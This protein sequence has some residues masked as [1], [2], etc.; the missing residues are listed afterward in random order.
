MIFSNR[1]M[2]PFHRMCIPMNHRPI[3]YPE[4]PKQLFSG[5]GRLPLLDVLTS[6][7]PHGLFQSP[8]DW[9]HVLCLHLGGPVAVSYGCSEHEKPGLRIHG[10]FC[11]VPCGSST[12]WILSK[13]AKSLLLRLRPSLL[14]EMAYARGVASGEFDLRPSI[15]IRDR[16]I[17]QIGWMMQFEAS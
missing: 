7:V 1:Y 16:Q 5:H 6:P 10:Q 11:V 8:V 12:R 15:H 13:P 17:E 4:P 14:E 2:N 3:S 9:R